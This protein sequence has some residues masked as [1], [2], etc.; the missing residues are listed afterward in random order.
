V[1]AEAEEL[2]EGERVL[3]QVEER[4]HQLER[5]EVRAETLLLT[6][7]VPALAVV[8]AAAVLEVAQAVALE[9]APEE[10]EVVVVAEAGA[11]EAVE[12]H[13]PP[14]PLHHS[15]LTPHTNACCDE[16]DCLKRL[17][18]RLRS[19]NALTV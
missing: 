6:P 16:L 17:V 11:A 10:A 9:A 4:P 3:G 12:D 7:A 8:L 19:A 15:L 13:L 18:R 2:V 5:A 14:Y 1:V